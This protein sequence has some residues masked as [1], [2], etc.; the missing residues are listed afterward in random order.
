VNT[1]VP[2]IVYFLCRA[3]AHYE[4]HNIGSAYLPPFKR[5]NVLVRSADPRIKPRT[6]MRSILLNIIVLYAIVLTGSA[7]PTVDQMLQFLEQYN[8]VCLCLILLR[9]HP[10]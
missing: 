3:L 2:Q 8:K 1:A 7:A 9:Q 4:K 10:G 6:P 5:P